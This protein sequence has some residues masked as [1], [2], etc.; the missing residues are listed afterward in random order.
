MAD[1]ILIVGGAG[2]LALNWAA[3]E[4]GRQRI[5]LGLHRRAVALSGVTSMALHPEAEGQLEAELLGARPDLLVNAAAV[6]SVEECE[7]D[8]ARAFRVNAELPGLIGRICARHRIP[9]VHISTDHLF[10]GDFPFATEEVSVAPQNAYAASK[11]DG[12]ARLL[13]V[14]A[15]AL[16]IRT[17]FYGWGPD[18]RRSFSDFIV[19]NL[20]AGKSINLFTDV[21][22][23]P[24]VASKLVRAI[25]DV[26]NAG[27]KGVVHVVGDERI[28]KHEFGHRLARHFALDAGLIR[29]ARFSD[30]ESMVKRPA[31]M[32]LSN[33]MARRLLGRSICGVDEGLQALA[34]QESV[35]LAGELRAVI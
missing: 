18:Y 4:R 2:L 7:T 22:Y 24:I 16:V 10:A 15:D 29:A 19:D 11:A 28:S 13:Q 30:Q 26:V 6:T 32:S 9:M 20:R 8:R 17:N 5:V 35:G 34:E 12:E 31:D 33:A 27:V 21:F 23:T 3:T 1:K 14:N 25:M